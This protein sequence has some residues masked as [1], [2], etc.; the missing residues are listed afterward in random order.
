MVDARGIV[1]QFNPWQPG[2]SDVALPW[3]GLR[4]LHERGGEHC[5]DVAGQE[6]ELPGPMVLDKGLAVG[7]EVAAHRTQHVPEAV[8]LILAVVRERQTISATGARLRG[9]ALRAGLLLREEADWERGE[10]PMDITRGEADS[11]VTWPISCIL[12]G[13]GAPRAGFSD[14]VNTDAG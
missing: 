1:L 5:W 6:V 2:S 12:I 11:D 8:V 9:L 13:V 10:E 3:R 4:E 7:V 14:S